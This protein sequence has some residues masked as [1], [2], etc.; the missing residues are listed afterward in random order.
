MSEIVVK[1]IA[2]E[3]EVAEEIEKIPK[4]VKLPKATDKK[5]DGIE[6]E[7]HATMFSK[8]KERPLLVKIKG[9]MIHIRPKG[10]G[11]IGRVHV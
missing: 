9:K 7:S 3:V 11:K 2:E 5:Y 1:V 4:P 6:V 8:G 10:H